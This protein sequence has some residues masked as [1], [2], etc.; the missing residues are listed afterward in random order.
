MNLKVP[1]NES[2]QGRAAIIRLE[3]FEDAVAAAEETLKKAQ[4]QLA[5]ERMRYAA[6]RPLTEAERLTLVEHVR[7]GG[8]LCCYVGLEW[9]RTKLPEP[10]AQAINGWAY[11]KSSCSPCTDVEREERTER[12]RNI[13][14]EE[15]LR[16][17]GED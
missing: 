12:V 3:F 7:T 6:D 9:L 15:I 1:P 5:T 10:W 17:M 13:T 8:A 16:H 2:E 4:F 11:D 14:T